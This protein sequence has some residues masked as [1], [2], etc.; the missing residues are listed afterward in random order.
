MKAFRSECR[1]NKLLLLKISL[2]SELHQVCSS[3]EVPSS[4]SKAGYTKD[5]AEIC[6]SGLD[7]EYTEKHRSVAQ[8]CNYLFVY[9]QD[10]E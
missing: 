5:I 3:G 7:K 6:I 9:G 4:E 1:D 8:F 2:K 10:T